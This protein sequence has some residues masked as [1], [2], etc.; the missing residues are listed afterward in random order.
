MEVEKKEK[1]SQKNTDLKKKNIKK[2]LV[3]RI[4]FFGA[5]D[6]LILTLG[7]TGKR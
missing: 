7:I 3:H 2:C 4:Q 5:T 6:L 1:K